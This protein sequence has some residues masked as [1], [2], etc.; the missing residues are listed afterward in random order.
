VNKK[1]KNADGGTLNSMNLLPEQ[2]EQNSESC[3]IEGKGIDFPYFRTVDPASRGALSVDDPVC[4]YLEVSNECNLACKT[5]P[6]TFGKVEQ[7]AALS[8]TQ[9][10]RLVPRI[11]TV[12]Q[13]VLH[14]VGEPL[15]NRELPRIIDWLKETG[16]Y[17]LFNSNGTLMNRR[18]Q[19]N[20]ILSRLDEIR[21]SLDAATP[22]S[23]ARVRGRPLFHRILENIKGLVSLKAERRSPTPLVSLWLTGLRETLRELHDFI[24][25]AHSLGIDRVYLQRL[26]FWEDENGDRLARPGESLFNSMGEEEKGIIRSGQ[27]LARELGIS[28]EASGATSPTASLVGNGLAKPWSACMRPWTLMYI[29]ARGSTFPCCIAPFSTE[30]LGKLSLGNAF[31]ENLAAIWNGERYQQFRTRLLSS[32]PPECCR[33]CGACWSL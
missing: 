22:E 25:L 18:W 4:L 31:T 24:R 13:V 15:L 11:S 1:T 29:S 30:N 33:A 19:E 14:G 23:F 12:K 8:L 27:A 32:D 17:V 3:S 21:V 6:I 2:T 5:C 7:P 20:L 28:F 10:K 9:V 16:I 26:V